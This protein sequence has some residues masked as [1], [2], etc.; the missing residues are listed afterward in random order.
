VYGELIECPN[1]GERNTADSTFCFKCGNKLTSD[2]S[3]GEA[4]AEKK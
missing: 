2:A 4:S 3:K 1:C